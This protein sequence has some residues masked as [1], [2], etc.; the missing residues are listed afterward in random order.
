MISSRALTGVRDGLVA[1]GAG[2]A[3]GF[4]VT[5]VASVVYR[6]RGHVGSP[7]DWLRVAGWLLAM[8]VGAP[9]RVHSGADHGELRLV[10]LT[11]TAVVVLVAAT[12]D[13]HGRRGRHGGNPV[14][15]VLTAS[16]AAALA[17]GLVSW[18]SAS[19]LHSYG[20]RL[21][22]SYSVSAWTA[23]VGA[24]LVVGLAYGLPSRLRGG[25]ARALAGGLTGL[26]VVGTAGALTTIGTALWRLPVSTAGA[27]PG[28]VGDGAAWFGGFSMGGRIGADLSS[29]IP[30]LSGSLG[31]GL[32]NGT[33]WTGAFALVLVPLAAAVLAGRRQ[34]RGAPEDV[35]PWAEFGRAVAVNA[36]LWFVLAEATRLRFS[37]HLGTD[38]LSGSAGLD[39]TSTVFVA[40]LWGGL[41]AV[42]GLARP[43][44]DDPPG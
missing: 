17:V 2:L 6:P 39:V 29:P 5:G 30:F 19:Q 16:L 31:W 40:A 35:S 11:V 41:S 24:A 23:A 44:L 43:P 8:A 32:I 18:A 21:D 14:A 27:L 9:L 15:A 38:A 12:H 13:R 10:P 3:V 28:L 26:A 7:L 42:V 4:V 22:V 25:W 34:Q 1:V 37:G 20:R 33:A 36:V